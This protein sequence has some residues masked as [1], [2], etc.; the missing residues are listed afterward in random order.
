MSRRG[1]TQYEID[2]QE[3]IMLIDSH[4]PDTDRY[5]DRDDDWDDE[6]VFEDDDVDEF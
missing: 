3:N 2:H 6:E 5:D 1:I 4:W